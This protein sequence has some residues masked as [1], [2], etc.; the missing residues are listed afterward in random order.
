MGAT[1]LLQPLIRRLDRLALKHKLG[2]TAGLILAPLLVLTFWLFLRGNWSIGLLV[3]GITGLTVY[4]LVALAGA[5]AAQIDG[6][7]SMTA[8]LIGGAQQIAQQPNTAD[9]L[10][11]IAQSLA[12]IAAEMALSG[13]YRQAIVD[14]AVDG[15]LTIDAHDTITT[16]NPAAE[17]IFG[18]SAAEIIGAPAARLIPDPLHRTYKLI[19]SGGEVIGR[20]RDGTYFPMDL[21]SGRVLLDERQL[22]V[23]IVRDVTRRKRADE[24]LQRALEAA[25]AASKAKSIFLANMSHELRTPLNAIIGYSELLSESVDDLDPLAIRQDLDRINSA[26]RHLLSLIDDVLDISK[27]EAGKMELHLSE[28]PL[29]PLIHDIG[30]AVGGLIRQNNN[31]LQVIYHNDPAEIW[32]DALRVRQILLNLLGNA[33]KFTRNGTITLRV[34]PTGSDPSGTVV[35]EVEDTG[36]GIAPEQ[37]ARL[38]EP[39]T[40]ADQSTTRRY[41]GTGLGLALTRRLSEMMNGSISVQS[42]PGAGSCFRVHLPITPINE[43]HTASHVPLFYPAD[44]ESTKD[45][46]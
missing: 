42:T 4:A 25:E 1:R 21:S 16:F 39:F 6:L 38:F 28:T 30:H 17:R 20:R 2:L 7:T 22:F 43:P 8:E 36:I 11:T 27:I 12:V 19:S 40:Q 32:A 26:G 15:I 14:H 31:Q 45:S 41:G 44:P 24:E 3:L 13:L 18:Y 37:V 34:F 35:F 33:A 23:V 29:A 46:D 10:G 9:E 5:L